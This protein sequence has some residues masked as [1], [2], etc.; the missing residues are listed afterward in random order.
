MVDE[1][2]SLD[3]YVIYS[4]IVDVN[5]RLILFLSMF[6]SGIFNQDNHDIISIEKEQKYFTRYQ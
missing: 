6:G 2:F 5:R 3:R 1:N 4:M